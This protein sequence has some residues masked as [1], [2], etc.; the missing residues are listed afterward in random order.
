MR[1]TA[2][3]WVPDQTGDVLAVVRVTPDGDTQIVAYM[4]DMPDD[5]ERDLEAVQQ[6]WTLRA[7]WPGDQVIQDG[8]RV[9]E[10]HKYPEEHD[11]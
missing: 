10:F 6:R 1:T 9:S 7:T 11:G 4:S 5:F 8:A 2:N 3:L